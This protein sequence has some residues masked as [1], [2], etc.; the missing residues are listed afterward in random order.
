M[1]LDAKPSIPS[2]ATLPDVLQQDEDKS[3][4]IVVTS[5]AEF[6]ENVVKVNKADGTETFYRGHADK[7]WVLLP[8]IFRTPN[9]VEKEHLLF[10]DMVAHEPQSFLECHSA[11]DYLVQMQ[12]Y[13]LPT[14]LLDVTTNPLVAL[15]FACEQV[16]NNISLGVLSGFCAANDASRG[17]F[18][19]AASLLNRDLGL[20][21]KSIKNIVDSTRAVLKDNPQ[22]DSLAIAKVIAQDYADKESIALAMI[23][24]MFVARAKG[25]IVSVSNTT[26]STIAGAVAGAGATAEA[27][28]VAS[29]VAMGSAELLSEIPVNPDD[30]FTAK[31][32]DLIAKFAVEFDMEFI[33][34]FITQVFIK[35]IIELTAKV[36][37]EAGAEAGAKARG[38]DGTVYLFSIPERKVKHYDSDTISVLANLAK[39]RISEECFN[40]SSLEE[41]NKQPDIDSLLQL[42]RGE[43]P[44]FRPEIRPRDLSSMFFVKAKNGNQRITNQMGA[45]LLF[46]LGIEQDKDTNEAGESLRLTKSIYAEIP[47][48]WIKVKFIVPKDKK[49]KILE[50][51][52]NLG[53]TESYIYPGMEQYAKELKKKYEL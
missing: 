43:K 29:V 39:S 44:Y 49:K 24:T 32:N 38:Q 34:E 18:E 53:I 5:V 6:I 10:R 14:R 28:I 1:S 9:G 22:A 45:F 11:L 2:G 33:D 46:G 17:I 21:V 52:A 20:V 4:P 50:E 13:G 35:L 47:P 48:E 27:S 36:G 7:D 30:E 19:T 26:T 23:A 51:L 37:A 42:I 25:R 3:T 12:H 40:Q 15:Y 31:L 16:E 8:S 41:F